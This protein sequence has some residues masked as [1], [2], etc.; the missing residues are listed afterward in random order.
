MPAQASSTMFGMTQRRSLFMT[1]AAMAQHQSNV[2]VQASA[3]R[4]FSTT[5]SKSIPRSKLKMYV[6]PHINLKQEMR[7][8]H[9]DQYVS[10]NLI[11]PSRHIMLSTRENAFCPSALR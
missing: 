10:H 3:Q 9:T 5:A 7:V 8:S 2:T 6:R 11:K 1:Q 4:D